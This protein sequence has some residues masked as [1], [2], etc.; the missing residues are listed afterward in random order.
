MSQHTSILCTGQ[1][2]IS[3]EIR[4]A[5]QPAMIDVVPYIE[6]YAIRDE[7]I[8]K[9]IQELETETINVVFTSFNAVTAVAGYLKTIPAGW[10][11]Y[12][13]S[14]KTQDVTAAQFGADR[15]V[16]TAPDSA[17]LATVIAKNGITEAVFFCGNIRM[18]TLPV[19]LAEKG[20]TLTEL[21]VY[22]TET[23]T[24]A[25]HKD[26]DAILFFSPSGVRSYFLK[27]KPTATTTMFA[28]GNTTA[29]E[30]AKYCSNNV[31]VSATPS[32]EKMLLM[33]AKWAQDN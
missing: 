12:C 14:G 13:L 19:S 24:T 32:K 10:R 29:A 20:I 16:A 21:I 30:I 9:R 7:S 31:V 22:Y 8:Q 25:S 28:I 5:C 17:T 11:I 6:V 23:Q 18:D 33:A 3:D 2:E 26:Y 27:N 1:I 4:M 15:I